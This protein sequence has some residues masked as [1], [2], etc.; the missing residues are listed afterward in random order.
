M[1]TEKL[2]QKEKSFQLQPLLIEVAS[3]QVAINDIT[4]ITL[5][6][7]GFI[8]SSSISDVGSN[9]KNGHFTARVPQK[10]FYSTIEKIDALGTEKYRQISGQ[11]VTEEFIDLAPGWIISKK[12]ETRLQEILK[13][14]T[15]VKDIIEVEHELERVRSEIESLTGRLNYLNQSVEMSTIAVTVMEPAPITGDALGI[16]DAIRGSVR[17]FIESVRGIIIFTGFIIPILIYLG[18]AI[19]ITLGIK[20]KI[21]PKLKR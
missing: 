20:N 7:G 17:G 3:V 2:C 10:S 9:R 8:S 11:D 16:S 14:A 21:L 1:Q 18:A 19:L 5:E 13:M 4:N 6:A 12:Q 15:T